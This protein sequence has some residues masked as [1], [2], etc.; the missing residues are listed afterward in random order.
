M[1]VAASLMVEGVIPKIE[2]ASAP[3][4]EETDDADS[5]EEETDDTDS[6]E[7]EGTSADPAEKQM[8]TPVVSM[9]VQRKRRLLPSVIKENMSSS[10]RSQ[11]RAKAG[12]AGR[13]NRPQPGPLT[14]PARGE[15]RVSEGNR[16]SPGAS[17]TPLPT[18]EASGR[19]CLISGG[20][21]RP[22]RQCSG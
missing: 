10:S 13:Q 5:A 6:A 2:S 3:G 12:S 19:C 21:R 17:G 1:W 15:R 11:K 4:R 7:E 20:N 9:G 18:P 22:W 8:D 14:M 16:G